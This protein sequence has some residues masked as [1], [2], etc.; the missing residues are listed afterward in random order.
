MKPDAWFLTAAERGNPATRLDRRHDDGLAWSSGNQVTPLIHGATYFEDSRPGSARSKPG[1]SCCSPTGAETPTSGCARD[2]PAVAGALCEAAR[3]GV[4]VKGLI[5]RS[6]LDKLAFSAEE[7][8]HLGEDLEAVGGECLLDM[9][10]RTGGSHHMKLAV[11]RHRRRPDLDVAF[12]GG[13]DLCHSRRDDQSHEGD[14]QKQPMAAVYGSRPPWHDL[15]AMIRGR[16]SA[17]SKR[18]S[19]S[20]GKTRLR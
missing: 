5:W 3:R 12:V 18:C 6:H 2:G 16:R 11:L 9:R 17:T 1:T 13:I 10:V 20:A 8:R 19:A 14:P 7:N 4:L 15:Q